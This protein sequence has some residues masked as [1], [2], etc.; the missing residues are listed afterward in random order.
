MTVKEFMEMIW[1]SEKMFIVLPDGNT[2]FIESVRCKFG[3]VFEA[4]IE[5]CGE[6]KVFNCEEL[7]E[8]GAEIV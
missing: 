1:T 6:L 4:V 8:G 2:G 3:I 7:F 5:V